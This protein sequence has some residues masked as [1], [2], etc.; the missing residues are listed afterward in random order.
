[1]DR[2][3]T[4]MELLVALAIAAILFAI[5]VP[6]IRNVATGSQLSSS[7]NDLLASIQLARSEAIKRNLSVSVCPS[8]NGDAD[9]DLGDDWEV[10]WMVV[11]ESTDE[12][13]QR[14]A[15]LP[16]GYRMTQDGGTA[17][18]VFRPI[19]LAGNPAVIT[20]CRE[21][22]LGSQERV[23][24]LRAAGTAQVTNTTTGV[25]P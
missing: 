9:C 8:S 2:G 12:V 20:A 13:I 4:L 17:A 10:G 7:A 1:V 19:G 14:E 5:G 16:D 21:D 24:T 18:L 25:C 23:L 3:F 15:A 6:T 22:P 11:V